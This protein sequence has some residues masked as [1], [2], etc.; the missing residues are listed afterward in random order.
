MLDYLKDADIDLVIAQATAAD[1]SNMKIHQQMIDQ[2]EHV[3]NEHGMEVLAIRDNP[4]YR[5]NVLLESLEINGLKETTIMMNEDK[6]NQNDEDY[7]RQFE[8]EN[9]S[10]HK[11]DLTDYFMVDGNFQ[12]VICSV[13]VYRDENHITNTYA[14]GFGPIFEKKITEI[15]EG[16]K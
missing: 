3:K 7:W 2:L 9:K 10:L 5:F 11:I 15:L 16:R 8:N 14:K 6:Q 1:T 13:I 4:R 12:P